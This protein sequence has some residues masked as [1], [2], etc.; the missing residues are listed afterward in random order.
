MIKNFFARRAFAFAFLMIAAVSVHAC[1]GKNKTATQ[2]S[3]ETQQS[4][5]TSASNSEQ[6]S[7]DDSLPETDRPYLNKLLPEARRIQQEHVIPI[8]V[9]MAIAIQETGWGKHEI[10]QNNHFGLR[11][12]SDDCVTL[13]KNGA[14][15]RYETCPDQAE[16]F[17]LFAKTLNELSDGNPGNIR[18]LYRNGYA[19]S[20]RWV[21]KVKRLRRQVRKTLDESG[22]RTLS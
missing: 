9:T 8:D 16:C 21:R 11:C 6:S 18:A 17:N 2:P 1:G 5:Q 22:I 7:K 10:G 13:N 15:I 14:N 4:V 19:S 20:P 3:A 12:T